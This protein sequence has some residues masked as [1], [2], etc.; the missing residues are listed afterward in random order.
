M[1]LINIINEQVLMLAQN[2]G[3][4]SDKDFADGISDLLLSPRDYC[5]DTGNRY[6]VNAVL[7]ER[8]VDKIRKHPIIWKMFFMF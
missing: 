4:L 1:K 3:A 2:E 6:Q 5:I 7:F 8:F